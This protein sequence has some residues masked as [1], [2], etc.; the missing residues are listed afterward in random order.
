MP[1]AQ[2]LRMSTVE[3]ECSITLQQDCIARYAQDNNFI[4]IDSYVDEGKSG[5]A[6]THRQGLRSLLNDVVSGRRGSGQFSSMT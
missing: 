3:Q 4:I 5:L 2:Y 1:A 6:A